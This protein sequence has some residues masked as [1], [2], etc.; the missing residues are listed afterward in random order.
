MSLDLNLFNCHEGTEFSC[1]NHFI[2]CVPFNSPVKKKISTWKPK[3][4][5]IVL[6][7]NPRDEIYHYYWLKGH[8]ILKYANGIL[9]VSWFFTSNKIYQRFWKLS[10]W[11]HSN[12]TQ[13]ELF[14]K[15]KY[16]IHEMLQRCS[17][18]DTKFAIFLEYEN[19]RRS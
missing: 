15:K 6:S 1:F 5:L 8:I 4:V 12:V 7:V 16:V 9:I 10:V 13:D 19:L 14:I 2:T 18:I 11:L 3:I 17:C